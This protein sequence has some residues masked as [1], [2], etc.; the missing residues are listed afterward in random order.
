VLAEQFGG[1]PAQ[2]TLQIATD[3][4]EIVGYA[5]SRGERFGPFGVSESQRGRGV[6]AVLL[7][8][9]LQAM[10]ARGFHCAWFLWTSDR[11]VTLYRRHGFEEVRRFALMSIAL[12]GER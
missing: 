12:P 4:G 3:N 10:R 8:T 11:A 6:G 1:D 7:A 9:T 2:T 5:Q